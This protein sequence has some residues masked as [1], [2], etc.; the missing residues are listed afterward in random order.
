MCLANAQRLSNSRHIW[1]GITFPFSSVKFSAI[2]DRTETIREDEGWRQLQTKLNGAAAAGATV[3]LVL[4][5]SLLIPPSC[6]CSLS[7]IETDL[8][9]ELRRRFLGHLIEVGKKCSSASQ[10]SLNFCGAIFVLRL[11]SLL[12]PPQQLLSQSIYQW[13]SECVLGE[14]Y[15]QWPRRRGL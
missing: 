5:I 1:L 7:A 3:V 9:L 11:F 15:G 8:L 14:K 13:S 2:K 4:G 6:S 12:S 10:G